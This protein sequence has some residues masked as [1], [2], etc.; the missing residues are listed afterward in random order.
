ME[1]NELIFKE[2]V[3]NGYAENK[4]KKVWDISERKFLYLTP[5]LAKGFLNLRSFPAY[6]KQVVD[7]EIALMKAHSKE[8]IKEINGE[9]FNLI[10]IFCGDGTKAIELMK[11][12]NGKGEIKYCPIN[13][14]NYLTDLAIKNVIEAK[15]P[16][17][18]EFKFQNCECNGKKLD[19]FIAGVRG[20][21]YG[22]NV[23]L[24][25]G[26][27]LA[28]YEIND[29]LFKLSNAM[30]PG[31]YLIIGNGIRTG[32][33]LASLETYKHDIWNSWF[34]HL[35]NGLGFN[36]E[37]VS[38]DA[39]FGNSRVEMFYKVNIDKDISHGGK[40]I[41]FKKGDEIL[42]AILYKYFDHEFEKFCKMY[43]SEVKLFKDEDN[44]Y[45]L[46]VCRK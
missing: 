42:A 18:K 38:Y 7:R 11:L 35:M 36:K 5:E 32:D 37:D 31:D 46:V 15:I 27:V 26:S 29:Y 2:F 34:I 25:L 41:S 1:I 21:K 10:D 4:E 45:A 13:V 33:R 3:R 39:R 17:V 24:L 19:D 23:I 16:N 40:K 43:F 9:N 20:G 22:R 28:S 30:L 12:F 6:K 8:L 44:E 14:T